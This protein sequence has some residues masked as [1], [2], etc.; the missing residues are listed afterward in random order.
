MSKALFKMEVKANYKL[1][2]L[3]AGI[4]TLYVSV[5]SAMYDPK[6]GNSLNEMAQ[7]MPELFAAFGMSNPGT[8]LLEFLITYLYGFLFLLIPFLFTLILSYRLIAKDIDQ[9]SMA[10]LLNTSY[11]RKQ[12][13]LTQLSVLVLSV[14]V[15]L[16]YACS[17]IV[18]GCEV[19]FQGELELLKFLVL[20]IGLFF[21]HLFLISLCYFFSCLC[22]EAKYAIGFGAGFGIVFFLLQMLSQVNDKIDWMKYLTPFT[23][24]QPDALI[25]YEANGFAG[26]LIFAFTSIVFMVFTLYR[27]KQKDLHL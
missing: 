10:Y 5:I 7:S 23:L 9:G 15:L 24:F 19:M 3:F 21:L 22:N 25:H 11:S 12:I 16:L 8:T 2:L 14:F 4:L 27:F 6:L 20:N 26:I 18:V 1:F 13:F 17:L